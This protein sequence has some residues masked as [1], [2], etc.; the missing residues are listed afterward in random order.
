MKNRLK[1][2]LQSALDTSEVLLSGPVGTRPNVLHRFPDVPAR[3][4]SQS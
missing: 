4:V 2:G 3:L 1:D